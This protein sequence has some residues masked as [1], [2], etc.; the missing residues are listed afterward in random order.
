M[1]DEHPGPSLPRL[2]RIS[3]DLR[4]IGSRALKSSSGNARENITRLLHLVETTPILAKEVG[5]ATRPESSPIEDLQA[6]RESWSHLNLPIEEDEELGY[7]QVLLEDVA[8]SDEAEF[9]RMTHRYAG[10]TGTRESVE[11][12]LHDSIQPYVSILSRRLAERIAA[13]ERA[14]GNSVEVNVSGGQP[15]VNVAQGGSRIVAKQEVRQEVGEALDAVA[16]LQQAISQE[17]TRDP[18]NPDLEALAELGEGVRE[19]LGRERPRKQFLKMFH[20]RIILLQ[21]SLTAAEGVFAKA[22]IVAEFLKGFI[23]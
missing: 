11:V 10:K 13:T 17:K 6:A 21:G 14:T 20:D 3:S 16:E 4:A 12:F 22:K 18:D 9:W 15:M 5:S 8:A 7:L 23:T 1:S 19:E 2:K